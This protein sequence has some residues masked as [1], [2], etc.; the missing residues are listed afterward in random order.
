LKNK[1]VDYLW[2]AYRPYDLQV[3]EGSKNVFEKIDNFQFEIKVDKNSV[4]KAQFSGNFFQP[5]V[6][7]AVD[8]KEI[9]P[10]IMTEIRNYFS[11][12]NYNKVE[13]SQAL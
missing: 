1:S 6:R 9:I 7:Y 13:A 11:Q 5:K 4:A 8:I 2:N 10:S 3:E 12:K